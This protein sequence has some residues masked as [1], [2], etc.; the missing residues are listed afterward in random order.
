MAEHVLDARGLKCPLPILKINKALKDL[1]SGETL[2]VFATD[3]GSAED[4]RDFC[5]ATGNELIESQQKGRT[6]SFLIKRLP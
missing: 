5:R 1:P 4:L 6:Y 2:R 3:P